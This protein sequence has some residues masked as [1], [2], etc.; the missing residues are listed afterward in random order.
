MGVYLVPAHVGLGSPHWDADARGL[1]CGLTFGANRAEVARAA[2]ESMAL[3]VNDV[4]EIVAAHAGQEIGRL[5]VDGGPSRNRF[6][7]SMAADLLN[8]PVTTCASPDASARGAGFL[9]GIAVGLWPDQESVGRLAAREHGDRLTP[10]MAS[11]H[12][13]DIVQ[14]WRQAIRR[15][16]LRA[17]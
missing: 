17:P 4:F 6:L 5:F 14:G 16:V 7:M 12:R 15:A 9:A 11:G 2:A 10:T 1:V 3:Q 13:A 8:H